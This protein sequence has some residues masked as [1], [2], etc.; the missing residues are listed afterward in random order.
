MNSGL[1]FTALIAKFKIHL[2]RGL[3]LIKKINSLNPISTPNIEYKGFDNLHIAKATVFISNHLS[4]EDITLL[5]DI[6]PKEIHLFIREKEVEYNR[7]ILKKR[8]YTAYKELNESLFDEME[9]VLK[10]GVPIFIFAENTITHNGM[11]MPIPSEIGAFIKRTSALVYPINI[12]GAPYIK[13]CL[14]KNELIKTTENIVITLGSPFRPHNDTED[15]SE[16]T[17]ANRIYKELINTKFY[18]LEKQNVNL[19]DELVNRV[20][21]LEAKDV[22]IQDETTTLSYKNFLLSVNVLGTKFEK[23]FQNEDKIAT[24]LPTSVAYALTLFSLFKAGKTPVLLNFSMGIQNLLDC[25]KTADI[26]TIVTSKKFIKTANLEDAISALSEQYRILYLEDIQSSLT[27]TEKLIGLADSKRYKKNKY[28]NDEII[29]FTSGSEDK[30]KGVILTHDNVHANLL[31]TISILQVKPNDKFLNVLPMF[32]SFGMTIGCILP[33]LFGLDVF[34]YASPIS[35]KKIPKFIYEHK[36]TIMFGTSTFFG[37]YGKFAESHHFQTMRYVIA[38]AEKLNEEV[39]RLWSDKF[40]IRIMEGYGVTETAPVISVNIGTT[41]KTGSVGQLLPGLTSKIE[42]VDGIKNG[43]NLMIK[44]PNV[45]RG[46]LI[47]NKGFIPHEG[48]YKTGDIVEL[49]DTEHVF[50][51]ARLKRFAKLGGEM[52]SLNTVEQIAFECFGH[53]GFASVSV[54]DNRKGE[55]IIL[56]TTS[57]DIKERTLKKYIKERKLSNLLVPN[58]IEIIEEIPILGT[59]KVDYVSLQEIAKDKFEK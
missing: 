35:Y 26:I 46:Y 36:S 17:V 54:A 29:L 38:G 18:S 44:G 59:G 42:E 27:S 37:N 10:N 45:M 28:N 8:M 55:K 47:Y 58:T 9:T 23:I 30:P 53:T 43:G 16:R 13:S 12:E 40:G 24:F 51:K 11:V 34:L 4:I 50:I 14:F 22:K 25:C 57:E 7:N 6:L 5:D 39:K 32:H 2:E 48:W 1:V 56:F 21:N 49:D 33:I 20:K 31:Q 19:Y 15:A 3:T 52:V 41:F